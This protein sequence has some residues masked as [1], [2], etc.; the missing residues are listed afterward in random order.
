LCGSIINLSIAGKRQGGVENR[1]S[2]C[3]LKFVFPVFPTIP[4]GDSASYQ[5]EGSINK[6]LSQNLKKR[7]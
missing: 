3:K 4:N 7:P 1:R 5:V 2:G 6:Y